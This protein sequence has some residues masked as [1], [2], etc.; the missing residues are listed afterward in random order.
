[1]LGL[2]RKRGGYELMGM[3]IYEL[4]EV[5][6]G[7]RKPIYELTSNLFLNSRLKIERLMQTL[8]GVGVSWMS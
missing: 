2:I 1:M 7:L 3:G 6:Y 5:I 4:K 8:R